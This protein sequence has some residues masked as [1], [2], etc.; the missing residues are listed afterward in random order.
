MFQLFF[1]QIGIFLTSIGPLI[2]G[3]GF[4]YFMLFYLGNGID[5]WVPEEIYNAFDW[6]DYLLLLLYTIIIPSF[7]LSFQDIK[8]FIISAQ[9]TIGATI[10]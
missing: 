2:F 10:I 6:K 8:N 5:A 4:T 1:N 9:D 3:I 7:I